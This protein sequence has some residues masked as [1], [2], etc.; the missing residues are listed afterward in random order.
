MAPAQPVVE[1]ETEKLDQKE[2]EEGTF[3]PVIL[4]ELKFKVFF[5]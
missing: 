1:D 5:F 3:H 2:E 4:T